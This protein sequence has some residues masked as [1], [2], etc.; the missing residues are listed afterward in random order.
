MKCFAVSNAFLFYSFDASA[1]TLCFSLKVELAAIKLLT[2]CKLVG[3][4]QL[5]AAC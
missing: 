4:H 1:S 3:M 2:L 5:F